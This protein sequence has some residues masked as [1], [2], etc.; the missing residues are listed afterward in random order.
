VLLTGRPSAR[1]L[2]RAIAGAVAV[3]AGAGIASAVEITTPQVIADYPHD[4]AAFT[5]GFLLHDG[6]FFESTGLYGSS[7]LRRVDRFTGV[8]QQQIPIDPDFF[9]EG[10][11]RV[12]DRLIQ[13]TWQENIAW[14]YDI[15]TFQRLDSFA[16]DG[17]GWGLC[18]DGTRLV[19]T[20]GSS[21]LFF[22]DPDTFQL[23][24]QIGVT[25]DGSS[26]SNLNE[27]ECVGNLV[28]A[29]VWLTDAILRI[30]PANGVVLTEIDARGL[31]TPRSTP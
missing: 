31:L 13:L 17:E 2:A 8:V 25:R 29:N 14:V 12:D 15:H 4:T 6:V 21:T 1:F 20:D 18:Y 23:L 10:L 7:S 24:G 26:V 9:A 30:D 28:Y 3:V 11:A 27:L 16:Y 5:Q 19:M 22:R